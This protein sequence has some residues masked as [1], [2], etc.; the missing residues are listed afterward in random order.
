MSEMTKYGFR[1]RTRGGMTVDNLVVQ[2]RSREDAE[3][4]IRQIYQH[5]E[6]LECSEIAA[7]TR[8]EGVD[9]ESMISLISRQD[10]PR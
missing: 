1:I 3:T 9:L 10:E 8:G 5:C 4:R 2:A 7:S 6:I